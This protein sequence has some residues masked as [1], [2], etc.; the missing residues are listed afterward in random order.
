MAALD[1]LRDKWEAISPRERRMV[2]LLGVSTVLVLIIYVALQIRDGLTALEAKNARARKALAALTAYK[3]QAQNTAAPD[4][5]SKLITTQA[6]KLESYIYRAGEKAQVTVPGVNTRTPS[7]K[8]SFVA[9]A[10][11]VEIRE[12]TLT[13]IKDFLEAIESESKVVVVSALQIR[14]NFRD[15]EKLDL[16]IEVVTWAKVAAEG[17]GAGSGSGSGSAA[18]SARAGG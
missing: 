16:N 3:A 2:V 7:P 9:H 18:G 11:T 5:P 6:L 15:K 1:Q 13:Q 17:E 4:D 14:R 8:G 12:A 10:A